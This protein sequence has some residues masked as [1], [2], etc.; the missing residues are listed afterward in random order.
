MRVKNA[1]SLSS[2]L[3]LKHDIL[4]FQNENFLELLRQAIR[5]QSSM[6]E[7]PH[8]LSYFVLCREARKRESFNNSGEGAG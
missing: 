4:K 8:S 7:H 6:L 3:N 5:Y 2:Q 1:I